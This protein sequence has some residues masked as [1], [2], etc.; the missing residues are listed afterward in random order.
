MT[1][2]ALTHRHGTNAPLSIGTPVD[3]AVLA[4]VKV[5]GRVITLVTMLAVAV[6]TAVAVLAMLAGPSGPGVFGNRALVV[7]SGS[8]SPEFAAGDLV[9]V[10]SIDPA[11]SGPVSPGTVITFRAAGAPGS[12]VTHRVARVTRGT[13]GTTTYVTKGD[14]NVTVDATAVRHTDVVGTVSMSLP[15]LG[16]TVTALHRWSTVALFVA[17][18]A[19][20]RIARLL[21]APRN[22]DA[23]PH[24]GF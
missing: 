20:A 1:F 11:T 18:F 19:F 17:T 2:P 5:A 9:I 22:T 7:T 3:R 14:A 13:D 10:H 12:L 8:M 16:Y 21:A 4:V 23:E 15:R 24:N 6:C